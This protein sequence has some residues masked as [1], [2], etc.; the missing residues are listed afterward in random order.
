MKKVIDLA[1]IAMLTVIVF[2]VEQALAFI[3]NIQLTV[4][5]FIVYTKIVGFKKTMVIILLHTMAD[6]LYNGSLNPF[7]FIP[8][9]L[10]WSMIPVL[11]STV[12]RKFDSPL[13]MMVF[14]FLFGFIYGMSF[15]P[16]TFYQFG[17]NIRAYFIADL[18]F[19][20]LMA[21]SGAVSVGLFY[22]PLMTF[23]K[24]QPVLQKDSYLMKR[25]SPP[26]KSL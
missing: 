14:A 2:T 15:I 22:T 25:Y 7:I 26:T 1:V 12:F 5:L 10:A 20:A 23:L 8:M 6:N 17:I 24:E 4:L 18:P 9:L 11:L 21:L 16:F 19:E 3:P 13:F